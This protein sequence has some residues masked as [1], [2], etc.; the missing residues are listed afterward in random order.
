[1]QKPDNMLKTISKA[2]YTRLLSP[3]LYKKDAD[4]NKMHPKYDISAEE[5]SARIN[6]ALEK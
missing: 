2:M 4:F 5:I 1:M 3:Q 6:V